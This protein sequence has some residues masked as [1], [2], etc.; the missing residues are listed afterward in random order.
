VVVVCGFEDQVWKAALVSCN[1]KH[2]HPM[3]S[4][5]KTGGASSGEVSDTCFLE[6][7]N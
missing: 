7:L 2:Q 6:L 4:S 5:S 1:S 3:A